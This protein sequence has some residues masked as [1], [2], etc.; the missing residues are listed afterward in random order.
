MN[1]ILVVDDE[2]DIRQ[3]IEDILRDEGFTVLAATN[4]R[5]MLKLLETVTPSLILLD[6]MM[7]D[8]NGIDAFQVMQRSSKL[9]DI[10][11][12]MMSAGFK[13]TDMKDVLHGWLPKPFDLEHLLELVWGIVGR[14]T[15]SEG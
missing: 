15:T 6:V 12:V 10:P 3:V 11:V 8:M 4:G 7:P 13:F 14:R 2:P 5:N 1:E 9:K